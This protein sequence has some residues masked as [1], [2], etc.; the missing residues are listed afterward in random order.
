MTTS[1]CAVIPAKATSQR[2]PSKNQSPILGVPLYLWAANNLSRVLSRSCIYVDS[3][4]SEIRK[5]AA[6]LGFS[7]IERPADLATNAT[8]GNALMRWA[9]QNTDA[10]LLVQHMATMPFLR[11]STLER[12]IALVEREFDSCVSMI[13]EPLYLW[14]ERGP[15]YD[16]RHVPNSFDLVPTRI[17]SM[18]L[19]VTRRSLVEETG[20]R[21]PGRVST[22]S[23]D[24]FEAID[25][26]TPSDLE[27]ARTVAQ[28]LSARGQSVGG[29]AT[30]EYL[31]GLDE[32]RKELCRL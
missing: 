29:A 15:T 22:V 19:Y 31:L 13:E 24:R 25:I 6:R 1:I 17:E 2:T 3:D 5:T 26:D 27:F 21:F 10:E 4:S 18:G 16:I 30:G 11:R 8:D 9:A 7:T 28:G 32:L 23:V 12:A 20:L 14:N